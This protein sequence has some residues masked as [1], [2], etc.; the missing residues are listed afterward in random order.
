MTSLGPSTIAGMG[1]EQVVAQMP[2]AVVVVEAGSGRIVHTNARARDMTERQIG[3]PMSP[4]LTPDWE[5]FHPDGSPYTTE[6]WPLV[7]SMTSG[8]DVVDE[9]Y[10]NV[11]PDGT[12]MM[13]RASSSPIYD[14]EGGIVAGVLL[15]TDV[16]EQKRV[17]ERLAYH[18]SL[19]DNM[20][21][22][23]IA[24]DDR[25]VVTAWNRGAER[26]YGRAADEVL[27]RHAQDVVKSE[28]SEAQRDDRFR[29]I[30]AV[31]HSRIEMVAYRK[32]GTPVDVE[33][34]N[35]A[36]RGERGETTGYLGI[37]RDVTE[38]KRAEEE[39]RQAARQT[40]RIL[41]DITDSFTALDREWRYTYL[42]ERALV[43]MQRAM[44]DDVTR[45][46]LLG[47]SCWEVFPELMGTIFDDELHA[48]LRE[49]NPVEFE[50]YLPTTDEWV[51]VNAYPWDDGLAVYSRVIT[52]RKRLEEKLTEVREAER[53][54]LAR[55]LHDEA[56]QELTYALTLAQ[57]G[58]TDPTGPAV[59]DQ[60]VSALK[61]VGQQLRGAIYDLRLEEQEDRAFP[62]LLTALVALHGA[63]AE[64]CE[65]VLDVRAGLPGDPLGRRGSEILRLVGEALTN[66]RRHSGGASIRVSAWGSDDHLCVEVADDG[67]GF[68]PDAEPAGGAGTGITG[69]WE[70]AALLDAA[71]AIRSRPGEG[72]TVRLE[73]G[74]AQG[75][76]AEA[77]PR[78]ARVL[79]V[80]DHAAVRQAIA[81]MFDR[82][83][84]FS[85]VGQAGT[86]A[87]ARGML[88]EVDVAV[89]DLGLP[90]GYGGDLIRELS[91][92]NPRAQA[93]VLSAGLD[94]SDTARAIESGAAGT[95]DKMA[96]LDELVDA[97]RRLRAGETLLDLDEVAELLRLAGDQ[98]E[99]DREHRQAIERL[100]PREREVLEALAQGR[101]SRAIA[102]RLQIS[103]RTQRNHVA[104]ILAK[105]G[106]HSQLQAVLLALRYGAV[107]SD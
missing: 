75:Q 59:P 3:R 84:D 50:S 92:V 93:L 8:E 10:F 55:D 58:R 74:L 17:E 49:Q 98:R 23:V 45:S 66:A 76:D 21:D 31:G 79:L 73:V 71:L 36:I 69:M 47:R 90:D 33:L 60:L 103:T 46:E 40:D 42:N 1:L 20:E 89:I 51:E 2:T 5:I 70:R 25:F 54:R 63:L 104:N 18:G 24:T 27:G 87:D 107:K 22:A 48:A 68:D 99:Q 101:D 19:V 15:M 35:V 41:E 77:G 105:L 94:R 88:D 57:A 100:T 28:L 11:L 96:Q 83:P 62:Q 85:V 61:R 95:L 34:V 14:D 30:A 4:N 12:R 81:A 80:E 44:R 38:R 102:D 97:V 106:V 6:D 9:E 67:R 43:R 16:T 26:L 37:H 32:D 82:E 52:E 56:L 13:I 64:D 53:R 39:L 7:R 86:L 91:H 78:T 65:L 29:E 72:T